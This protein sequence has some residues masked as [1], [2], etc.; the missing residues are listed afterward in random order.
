MDLSSEDLKI[1]K[2]IGFWLNGAPTPVE[3]QTG[4]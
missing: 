4:G 1:Q 2:K 3:K